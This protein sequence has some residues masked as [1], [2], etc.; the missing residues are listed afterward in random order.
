MGG[1]IRY[2]F[3]ANP[4]FTTPYPDVLTSSARVTQTALSI[5]KLL[6]IAAI[7]LRTEPVFSSIGRVRMYAE[8]A[9]W[10]ALTWVS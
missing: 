9:S 4:I 10:L 8:M 5:D 7:A 3:Y 2:R 6:S 1:L